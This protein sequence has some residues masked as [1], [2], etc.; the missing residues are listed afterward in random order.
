MDVFTLTVP[1]A[2]DEGN[3]MFASPDVGTDVWVVQS[4][5]FNEFTAQCRH[6]VFAVVEPSTWKSPAG[7][8]GKFEAH[9]QDVLGW[10]E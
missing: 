1:S 8:G 10:G 7:A 9:Q 4:D 6:V 2:V 3:A 5:F